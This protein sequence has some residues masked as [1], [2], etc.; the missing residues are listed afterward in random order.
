MGESANIFSIFQIHF[1][2][3]VFGRESNSI[4]S[5]DHSRT[6][7]NVRT[8]G[9]RAAHTEEVKAC[10]GSAGAV[11]QG[12]AVLAAGRAPGP[13]HHTSTGVWP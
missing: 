8:T 6:I 5:F 1:I 12:S 3:R 10:V 4:V 7:V 11:S 2:N 9:V 13:N